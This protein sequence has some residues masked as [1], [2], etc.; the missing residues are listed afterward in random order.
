M[1]VGGVTENVGTC[2]PASLAVGLSKSGGWPGVHTGTSMVYSTVSIQKVA[3]ICN[4]CALGEVATGWVPS[5]NR[6]AM[7][8]VP[9][10][11]VGAPG[12]TGGDAG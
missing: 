9:P 10:P 5:P 12:M 1:S 7:L 11:N 3:V 6:K 8:S 2:W 4:A